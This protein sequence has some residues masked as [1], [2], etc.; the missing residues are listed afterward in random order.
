MSKLVGIDYGT[1]R[2]GVALSDESGS[3]AF[4]YATY[5]NDRTLLPL[6]AQIICKENV[7][8][9]IFGD[10]KNAEGKDN[11]IMQGAYA[12]AEA[13]QELVAV[14]V[15]FEPEFYSTVEARQHTG[16]FAVDAEAATIILN[17]YIEKHKKS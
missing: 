12:L 4:P 2:V 6:L 1:K 7:T 15:H 9:A 5:A 17:S 3:I 14:S 10:S 11:S 13:L 8:I 16:K